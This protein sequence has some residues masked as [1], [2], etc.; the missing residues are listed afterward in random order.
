MTNRHNT[1]HKRY[2]YNIN[3]SKNILENNN[4]TIVRVD[5]RKAI[6]VINKKQPRKEV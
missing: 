5:K 1:V 3:Q 4:L 6:V 2:Q